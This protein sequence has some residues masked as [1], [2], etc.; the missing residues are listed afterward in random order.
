MI[1]L[2][3]NEAPSF[4]DPPSFPD[5]CKWNSFTA[6]CRLECLSKFSCWPDPLFDA[7]W[8]VH[9]AFTVGSEK[10]VHVRQDGPRPLGH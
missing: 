1:A 9:L 3:G 2:P 5:L 8:L 7:D 4:L 10:L 6:S